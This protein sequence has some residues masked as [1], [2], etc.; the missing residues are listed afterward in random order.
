MKHLLWLLAGTL[1]HFVG[2]A[3]IAVTEFMNN[4]SG[5]EPALEWMEL[6]N[7]SDTAINLNGWGLAD[8]DRDR[9]YITGNHVMLPGDYVV[10]SRSK[11]DFENQW[12][13]GRTDPA[14]I[15]YSGFTLANGSDEIVLLNSLGEAVWQLAYGNDES[16]GRAT[17]LEYAHDFDRRIIDWG[18]KAS[19]GINR[20]GVDPA[21]Q[22]IGYESTDHHADSWAV[23]A[24]AS[25]GNT[26]VGSPLRGNYQLR[27]HF[28]GCTAV[29]DTVLVINAF[30]IRVFFSQ[31][32]GI[33]AAN[34]DAYTGI[35][36]LSTAKRDSLFR[37][38]TLSYASGIK[39]GEYTLQIDHILDT[40][41]RAVAGPYT[42]AIKVSYSRSELV[43][44]EIMYNPAG[45][46][47]YEFIEVMNWGDAAA[48]LEGLS[49]WD[50][51]GKMAHFP[52][53]ILAPDSFILFARDADA[54]SDVF[55]RFFYDTD[56]A[57]NN[58]GDAV[59]IRNSAGTI[60]DRVIY[61]DGH[62]WPREAD[63]KGAS[64]EIADPGADNNVAVNWRASKAIAARKGQTLF[65]ASPGML[66]GVIPGSI[67]W[68]NSG[69]A[70]LEG[71]TLT[72]Y[73]YLKNSKG[74]PVKAQVALSDRSEA[75]P[76]D[77][78]LAPELFRDGEDG[79]IPIEIMLNRDFL[80]EA[81]EVLLLKLTDIENARFTGDSLLRLQILD[82]DQAFPRICLNEVL[83][84][85]THHEDSIYLDE[86]GEAEP[87]I[88][89]F[90]PNREWVDISGLE[91]VLAS[92][93][94]YQ[95]PDDS[96]ELNI[97]PYGFLL[98]WADGEPEEGSRHLGW[99]FS[100]QHD[101]LRLTTSGGVTVLDSISLG[102][103][104][105][106]SRGAREDCG[107]SIVS[108]HSTPGSSNQTLGIDAIMTTVMPVAYPNPAETTLYFSK[109]LCYQLFTDSG[110]IV[111]TGYGM[112]VSVADLQPGVYLLRN[113]SG[114]EIMRFKRR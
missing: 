60:I 44:T 105:D 28:T 32:V 66:H 17:F 21:S 73:A 42:A 6:Y 85:N 102:L 51:G 97:A 88:E 14:V 93:A 100:P 29:I 113:M 65:F 87:Y 94:S 52:A 75:E 7:Y 58:G 64:L 86:Q 91:L 12:L 53:K 20:N 99:T 24:V 96:N 27:P 10:L 33:S 54:A 40:E 103:P 83:V 3:Q 46:D 80:Q 15:A 37:A 48:E 50:Q 95:L 19:A 90:N 101:Q 104:F 70:A 47:D 1:A 76:S 79:I 78:T 109:P 81:N 26:D 18:S 39:P 5:S 4:P 16:A 72:I 25:N 59:L 36:G 84:Q 43:I 69:V 61:N 22:T 110:Q 74:A 114:T 82:S 13:C 57:L 89:I 34:T 106:Q 62:G 41:G 45:P 63:G 55:G 92:D 38:V 108:I 68:I 11:E 98:L 8:E 30:T 112:Q 71:E 111:K 9:T 2:A 67:S 77:F 35:P 31:P 107:E 49:L 56:R 23:T